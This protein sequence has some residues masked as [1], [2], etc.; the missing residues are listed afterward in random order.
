[1]KAGW[2]MDA[3]CSLIAG[4]AQLPRDVTRFSEA[5]STLFFNVPG[6][7]I[8]ASVT[9]QCAHLSVTLQVS[10]GG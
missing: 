7:K 1:M 9:E 2:M 5:E 4:L 10:C 8:L 6:K 3:V